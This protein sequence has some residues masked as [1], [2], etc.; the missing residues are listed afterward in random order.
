MTQPASQT[1]APAAG[2]SD[3]APP[4]LDVTYRNYDGP[5]HSRAVRWWIVSLATIRLATRRWWFWLLAIIST[6]PYLFFGIMLYV[7]SQMPEGPRQQ[8]LGA[9]ADHQYAGIF[10]QAFDQHLFWLML[11]GLAAGAATIANDNRTNALQVY[12]ARPITKGDY[13]LGKCAGVFLII[14]AAAFAPALVLYLFCLLS[15]MSE[16]FL[17]QEPW[18][19]LRILGACAIA[20]AAYTSLIV[21]VS[22]WCRSGL[23]AGAI[24]AGAYFAT[25]IISGI[26]WLV[27][28]FGEIRSGAAMT[29][30]VLVQH[31]SISG[32]INGLAWNVF[33]VTLRIPM[34][35]RR[36]GMPE[37]V[38]MVPPNVWV[39]A[40]AVALIVVG[41]FVAARVR[42]RAVEVV[43][44]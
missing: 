2:T 8:V 15:Y 39:M 25:S 19:I 42:V 16:G 36:R 38:E 11:I 23:I 43:R 9:A 17:R 18:L 35:Q 31:A 27:L 29:R 28:F 6:W 37:I 30:G 4:I 44:G 12:L 13:V 1:G 41:G 10:Y 34:F 33:A 32:V 7:Q 22:A 3:A 40:A 5:L 14:L 24:S 21:G 26:L 20:A